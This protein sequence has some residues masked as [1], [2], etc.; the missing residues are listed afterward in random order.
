MP[1]GSL[2]AEQAETTEIDQASTMSFQVQLAEPRKQGEQEQLMPPQL[3][4]Q[5]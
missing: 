1:T 3:E 2:I 4:K 5:A